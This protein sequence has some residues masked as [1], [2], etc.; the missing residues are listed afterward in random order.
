M[1]RQYGGAVLEPRSCLRW[2][3]FATLPEWCRGDPPFLRIS[4]GI[5][6]QSTSNASA[7]STTAGIQEAAEM[8]GA[9][10]T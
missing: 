8:E 1:R 6:D 2:C 10:R 7:L 5:S 3:G 9:P 4:L